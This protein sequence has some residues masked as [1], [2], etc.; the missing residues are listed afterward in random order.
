MTCDEIRALPAGPELDRLVA[1]RVMGWEGRV[2][3]TPSRDIAFAWQV[4]DYLTQV[5]QWSDFHVEYSCGGSPNDPPGWLAY[6]PGA[7]DATGETAP[8]AIC[9]AALLAILEGAAPL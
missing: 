1:E 4:V 5:R 6:F 9:R 2:G 8:L 3:F 7:T